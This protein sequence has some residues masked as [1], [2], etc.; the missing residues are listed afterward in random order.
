MNISHLIGFT[1][2]GHSSRKVTGLM[3][4]YNFLFHMNLDFPI[5]YTYAM[6]RQNI[7]RTL[8]NSEPAVFYPKTP[9]LFSRTSNPLLH[10]SKNRFSWEIKHKYREFSPTPRPLS[11]KAALNTCI[12]CVSIKSEII[13]KYSMFLLENRIYLLT[14][15]C[16]SLSEQ[17]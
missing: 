10:T 8:F 12:V 5:L 6:Y 4:S 1:I 13:G 17:K 7:A 16:L 11:G 14:K 15:L 2:S 3:H 9:L